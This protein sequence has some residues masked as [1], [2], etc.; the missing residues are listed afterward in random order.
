MAY[1]SEPDVLYH[2]KGDGTF[3]DVTQAMGINDIDG[4]AMGV[5]AADVENILPIRGRCPELLSVRPAR[6]R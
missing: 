1:E 6:L 2:N 3:E 5:G 4:R